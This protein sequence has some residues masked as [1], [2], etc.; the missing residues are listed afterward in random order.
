MRGTTIPLVEAAAAA[1]AAAAVSGTEH[2][3]PGSASRRLA[4][5]FVQQ[6]TA[7][8]AAINKK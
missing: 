3:K 5:R 4:G 7:T 6:K 8:T 1:K 2:N